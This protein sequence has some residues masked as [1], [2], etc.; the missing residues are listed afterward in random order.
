MKNGEHVIGL[1][2]GMFDSNILTFNLGWDNNA[3]PI[4]DFTDVRTLQRQLKDCGIDMIT[5]AKEKAQLASEVYD[6]RSDGN[7][8]LL[9]QHL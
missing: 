3:Q 8:I 5:E 1:F 2:Q 6:C 9:D 4:G 7:P